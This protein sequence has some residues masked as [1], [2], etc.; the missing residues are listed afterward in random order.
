MAICH[1]FLPSYREV[2]VKRRQI[3]KPTFVNA[4]RIRDS[5][6]GKGFPTATRNRLLRLFK[7]PS[8]HNAAVGRFFMGKQQFYRARR[9][10]RRPR[11]PRVS[12][13]A[14]ASRPA[15][16]VKLTALR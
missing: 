4:Y 14:N 3:G 1:L 10:V 16:V 11:A 9:A 7:T 15:G 8:D 2:S 12:A 5:A 6:S 13:L